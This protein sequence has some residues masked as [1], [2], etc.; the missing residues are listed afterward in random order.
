[1]RSIIKFSKPCFAISV[2][3][4]LKLQTI[5]FLGDACS[6]RLFKR[7]AIVIITKKKNLW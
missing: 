5:Y 7:I 3:N 4:T 2:S 1:M 6:F